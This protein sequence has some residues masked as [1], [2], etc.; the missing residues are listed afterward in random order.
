MAIKILYPD[1]TIGRKT[2]SQSTFTLKE[3][4]NKVPETVDMQ[5]GVIYKSTYDQENI[6]EDDIELIILIPVDKNIHRKIPVSQTPVLNEKIAHVL[7]PII[8]TPNTQTCAMWETSTTATQKDVMIICNNN[9][10]KKKAIYINNPQN[11]YTGNNALIPITEGDYLLKTR[12]NHELFTTS[13]YNIIAVNR[14]T[15][16]AV[17]T[18]TDILSDDPEMSK[19]GYDRG[20]QLYPHLRPAIR[21]S[22][23]K[24][25]KGQTFD[26]HYCEYQHLI[27]Q[28]YQP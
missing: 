3:F 6:R 5:I 12:K 1:D 8:M 15:Q 2:F 9:G 27:K 13:I 26:I 18:L 25:R 7:Y 28:R 24:A 14:N 20:Y 19:I 4:R 21:S 23:R 16:T 17:T 10:N 11:E 22:K